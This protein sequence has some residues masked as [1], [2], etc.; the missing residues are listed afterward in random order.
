MARI[1]Q[2]LLSLFRRILNALF[3]QLLS[4]FLVIFINR[5]SI[6]DGCEWFLSVLLSIFA[7]SNPHWFVR[8]AQFVSMQTEIFVKVLPLGMYSNIS[9]G[10]T[11]SLQL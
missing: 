9:V 7:Q 11:L 5:I 6:Y 3:K 1:Q 4:L 8:F 10:A 2:R